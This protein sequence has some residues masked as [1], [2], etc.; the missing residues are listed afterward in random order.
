M[1]RKILVII[2]NSILNNDFVLRYQIRSIKNINFDNFDFLNLSFEN[3]EELKNILFSKQYFSKKFYDEKS[4]N[5]HT[6]A[7]LN[8]AKKIGGAKIISISKQ[9][10]INWYKKKYNSSSSV[11]DEIIISKRLLNLIYNYDFYAT[12]ATEKEK[13]IFKF[14]ILKNYFVL[15]LKAVFLK[16]IHEQPIEIFKTLLLLHSI[17]NLKVDKIVTQINNQINYQ[18]NKSGLHKSINPSTHAEFINELYE[19]KNICLY[20]KISIPKTVENHII[21][22]SSVLKNLFHKD[23]TIA[24]FNGSN[25]ANYNQLIKIN[26]LFKDIKP[27]NLSEEKDGLVVFEFKKIKIFFDITIPTSKLLSHNLHSGTLSF[28]MSYDKEKIIT[29]CGSIEKRI[30][31][32]PEYLRLSAAH[33]T[34]IINNTNISELVEKKSYKRIPKNI[35]FNKQQDDKKTI[36]ESSHDGY[37]NNYK[38][39][40]QRKLIISKNNPS[41]AGRDSIISIGLNQKKILYNIR[42]HLT[43]NCSCLLTNNKKSVLIKTKLNNSWIFNSE[44]KLT[45]EDSIYIYDG[46]RICKTK[47]IV[48]SGLTSSSKTIENWS[49]SKLN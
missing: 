20:F 34:I 15:K 45:L 3:H 22:M 30:G 37:K 47:Q 6:F 2:L 28:E 29:N 35:T 10:I 42:F 25:N 14:V 41:I 27:K 19:I 23:N 12:S 36:W 4:M 8:T 1:I 33:S 39:I 13:N 21:N 26:N 49:I 46:K 43:P 48:I 32:R 31:R 11:W 16:D 24:L 40:V 9:H 18:V 5:Y 44:S 38:K 7:W 17:N